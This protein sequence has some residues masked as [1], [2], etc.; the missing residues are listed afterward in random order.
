LRKSGQ[1]TREKRYALFWKALAEGI[2]MS[3]PRIIVVFGATG[4][5]GGGL[6]RAILVDRDR[7]FTVRAVTRKPNSQQARA[8]AAAG[9]EVVTADLDDSESIERAM[10]GAAGAFCVTNFWDHCSPE[11]ELRQA[12]TLAESARRAGVEH[13]IWSTLEDTR[14]FIPP[15]GK[16][17]PVFFQSYNVPHLDAKGE[18]NREFT[19][20]GVPVTLLYTSVYWDNL[21]H[22][23]MGPTAEP[24][25]TLTIAFPLGEAKLPGIAVE[26]IGGCALALFRRG[27][28]VIGRSLGIS[29]EHLSGT[30]MAVKLTQVLGRVVTYKAISADTYRSL[31]FPGAPYLGNMFQFCRDFEGICRALRDVDATRHLL[32]ELLTFDQWALRKRSELTAPPPQ[33]NA[34]QCL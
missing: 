25:G 3:K 33:N 22:F 5:Q 1:N 20:R 19:R 16:L 8:L 9:A 21:I 24:D 11:K 13:V 4:A 18:A 23:H 26:D 34:Y 32:P 28:E 6:A 2:A 29:G 10:R 14:A 15:D 30:Q 7:A 31:S 27:T 12:T 17:M